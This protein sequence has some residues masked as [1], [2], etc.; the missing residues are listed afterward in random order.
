MNN[1]EIDAQI[2]S[3][4]Q[5]AI[6]KLIDDAIKARRCKFEIALMSVA[7]FAAICVALL[8]VALYI[9]EHRP[10]FSHRT[11]LLFTVIVMAYAFPKFYKNAYD[12]ILIRS[13]RRVFVQSKGPKDGI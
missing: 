6:N 2:D 1:K 12:A 5:D 3:L 9:G 7:F 11:Y 8:H 10:P 13:A 4:P